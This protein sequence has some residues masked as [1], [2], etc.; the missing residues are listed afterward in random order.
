[1]DI[2]ASHTRLES[3]VNPTRKNLRAR[4]VKQV[5]FPHL[6]FASRRRK[7]AG[8]TP[9]FCPPLPLAKSARAYPHAVLSAATHI[10]LPAL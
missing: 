2:R 9:T 1:M 3:S 6:K 8:I 7:E 5:H 4:L 10:L